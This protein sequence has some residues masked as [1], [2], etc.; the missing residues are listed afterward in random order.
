MST[1]TTT[2]PS[3]EAPRTSG[4]RILVAGAVVAG[5]VVAGAVAIP[6]LTAQTASP[7]YTAVTPHDAVEHQLD[8]SRAAAIGAAQRLQS[9]HQQTQLDLGAKHAAAASAT[10]AYQ[11][12]AY[13]PQLQP[14]STRAYVG[15]QLQTVEIPRLVESSVV[16]EQTG[17]IGH[18]T[19]TP[20]RMTQVYVGSTLELVPVTSA[21][22]ASAVAPST[23]REQVGGQAPTYG[24]VPTHVGSVHKQQ[25]GQQGHYPYVPNKVYAATA[26]RGLPGIAVPSVRTEQ[27]GGEHSGYAYRPAARTLHLTWTDPWV[28]PYD[29]PAWAPYITSHYFQPVTTRVAPTHEYR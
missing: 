17:T 21:G 12:M 29:D 25:T 4:R 3:F 15:G 22:L 18:Y 8:A 11:P 28:P 14:G 13:Q 27:V 7:T 10:R 23:M 5:L 16:A 9:Q 20:P 2:A 6:R 24:W 26:E 1:I 19:W